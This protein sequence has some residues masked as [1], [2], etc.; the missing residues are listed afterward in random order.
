MAS[1]MHCVDCKKTVMKVIGV[2]NYFI[3]SCDENSVVHFHCELDKPCKG[4]KKPW[5][6]NE[7]AKKKK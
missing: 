5:N 6:K 7:F 3:C 1:E 2:K 4:C